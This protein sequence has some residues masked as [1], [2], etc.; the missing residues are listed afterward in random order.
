MGERLV[1]TVGVRLALPV[2]DSVSA[3]VA[4][5]EPLQLELPLLL[6]GAL[7]DA[8][9][10]GVPHELREA[11][12]PPGEGEP[13]RSGVGVAEAALPPAEGVALERAV[14]VLQRLTAA[15]ADTEGEGLREGEG[16]GEAVTEGVTVPVPVGEEE[17][18][19]EP[20]EE[21]PPP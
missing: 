18:E 11:V 10:D 12:P 8:E 4:L 3:A 16:N 9:N 15:L 1:V 5:G 2:S 17:E 13:V 19:A 6:G 20:E 14:R 7:V 21:P